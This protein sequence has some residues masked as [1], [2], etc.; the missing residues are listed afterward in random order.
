MSVTHPYEDVVY[1]IEYIKLKFRE[2][3]KTGNITLITI[4][5]EIASK[6]SMDEFF[7]LNINI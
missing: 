2:G 6:K 1:V 4:N 3:D 7:L 5:L